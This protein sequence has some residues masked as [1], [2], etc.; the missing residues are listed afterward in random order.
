MG[1]VACLLLESGDFLLQE[2]GGKLALEPFQYIVVANSGMYNVTGK[3]ATITI[4]GAPPAPTL[5]VLVKLRS[6][7]ERRRF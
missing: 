6:F 2:D 5:D 7:T 4:S 1:T 3:S